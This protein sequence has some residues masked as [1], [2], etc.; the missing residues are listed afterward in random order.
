MYKSEGMMRGRIL[1]LHKDQ[2]KE[3]KESRDQ[4]EEK[5]REG[6]R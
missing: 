2:D 6:Q 4:E 5:T 3:H 1:L